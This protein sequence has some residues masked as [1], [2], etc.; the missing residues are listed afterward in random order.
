[1]WQATPCAANSTR[2]VTELVSEKKH[3]FFVKHCKKVTKNK[4]RSPYQKLDKNSTLHYH[5]Y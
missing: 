4:Y 1:M 3:V 5:D 2:D